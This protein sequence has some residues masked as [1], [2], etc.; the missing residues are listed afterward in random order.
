[1]RTLT[2]AG[3]FLIMVTLV[4]GALALNACRLGIPAGSGVSHTEE[5]SVR[6]F[7]R[8]AFT[9]LGEM[10]IVQD[11]SESLTITG[12]DNIVPRIVTEV[13]D[14]MLT[15]RSTPGSVGQPVVPLRYELHVKD[16]SGITLSGLGSIDAEAL[17]A[18]R[19]RLVMSGAGS[20]E[21]EQLAAEEVDSTLSGL[22]NVTIGGEVT[23]Q[24]VLVSGAG[25]FA[26]EALRSA[27]ADVAVTGLGSAAVNVSERLTAEISGSGSITYVGRPEVEQTVTG[28]GSIRRGEG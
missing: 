5:R 3:T 18:S 19:L 13:A 12:D 8:V 1:M 4:V 6:D 26:G 23:H 14:G 10:T 24:E 15:I 21:I 28:L 17:R 9:F 27:V 25:N 11:G 7:D 22:G 16:L 20:L 2:I